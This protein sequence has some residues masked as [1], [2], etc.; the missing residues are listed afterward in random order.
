[1]VLLFF[2]V[3]CYH[4]FPYFFFIGLFYSQL[5]YKY[6][7]FSFILTREYWLISLYTQHPEYYKTSQCCLATMISLCSVNYLLH[8]WDNFL[9]H[10]SPLFL[11]NIGWQRACLYGCTSKS[12]IPLV[13]APRYCAFL[14]TILVELPLLGPESFLCLLHSGFYPLSPTKEH[15]N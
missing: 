3:H 1:M 4:F 11:P 7:L 8:I 15:D 14:H 13:S 2:I 10:P 6:E 9:P 5:L 12:T